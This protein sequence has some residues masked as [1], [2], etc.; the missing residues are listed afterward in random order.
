MSG[1]AANNPSLSASFPSHAI[2][3]NLK[4]DRKDLKNKA[5]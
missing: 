2:S 5:F 1:A 3:G 4:K